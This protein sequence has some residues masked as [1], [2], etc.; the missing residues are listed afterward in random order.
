MV[1]GAWLVL[2]GPANVMV[3]TRWKRGNVSR[4]MVVDCSIWAIPEIIHVKDCR[5]GEQIANII[6]GRGK[7]KRNKVK[8]L[9]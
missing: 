3:S 1:L 6:A 8:E 9:T 7:V 2:S 4:E 5:S